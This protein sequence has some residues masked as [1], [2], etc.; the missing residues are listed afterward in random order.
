MAFGLVGLG[1]VAGLAAAVA[2]LSG[3]AGLGA[4]FALYTLVGLLTVSVGIAAMLVSV[5]ARDSR[6]A[7]RAA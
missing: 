3:G 5:P 7:E 4:A 6:L 2:A 1:M